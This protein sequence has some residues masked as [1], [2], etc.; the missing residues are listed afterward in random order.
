MKAISEEIPVQ[1]Q[2]VI[3]Y[4]EKEKKDFLLLSQGA[5]LFPLQQYGTTLAYVKGQKNI[6][7]KK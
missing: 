7:F 3:D 2:A 5:E 6:F 1:K 4:T